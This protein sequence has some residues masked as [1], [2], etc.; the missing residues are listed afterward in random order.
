V[1]CNGYKR[2]DGTSAPPDYSYTFTG[3][4]LLKYLVDD[5]T[6]DAKSVNTNS[7]PIFRYAE[8]LLNLAEAKA[9]LGT[10]TAADWTN[11]IA[12]LR[13]RAGITNITY[14]TSLDPYLQQK[15]YPNITDAALMEIRRERGVELMMEGLRFDDIRRWKAGAL[16]NLPYN[17]VYVPQLNTPYAMNGDGKLNVAFVTKAPTSG[18]VPG[19]YYYTING[20]LAQLTQGDHGNIIWLANTP[21]VWNDKMY[22]YPVST[23]DLVLNPKLG[24]NPGW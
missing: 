9:E 6:L 14:P 16:M 3:Y 18:A 24:Q 20:T 17:G 2:S 1:R 19:V 8:V 12:L 15:Y 13:K 4:Q 22:L 7:L 5:K 10:F 11:T 21:R 23:A